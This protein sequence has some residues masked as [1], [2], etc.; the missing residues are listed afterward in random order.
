MLVN[1]LLDQVR[2]ALVT[3]YVSISIDSLDRWTGITPGTGSIAPQSGEVIRIARFQDGA[4][5]DEDFGGQPA[6]V[7]VCN[8]SWG[9]TPTKGHLDAIEEIRRRG[10]PYDYYWVDAGWYGTSTKP[11][12]SVFE[13]EWS[14][15][16]DWRVNQ[17]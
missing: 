10:L 9:G 16:G 12:P 7:P 1:R 2:G 6:P 4:F 8:G 14:I 15:T 17:A 5:S 13:G 11:C 3:G